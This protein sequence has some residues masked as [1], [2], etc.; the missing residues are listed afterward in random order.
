MCEPG[1]G[2]R[3]RK[4]VTRVGDPIYPSE[5]STKF[6]LLQLIER[7]AYLLDKPCKGVSAADRA[8]R[9]KF[10]LSRD[11]DDRVGIVCI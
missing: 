11:D 6:P 7:S 9:F 2:S 5:Y 4:S 10:N 3:I 1:A 8:I